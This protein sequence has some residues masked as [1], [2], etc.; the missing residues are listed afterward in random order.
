M[1]KI[2]FV[3]LVIQ[4]IANAQSYI[5]S[6]YQFG[7]LNS[8]INAQNILDGQGYLNENFKT[9]FIN[10]LDSENQIFLES[11]Y[12]L[13]YDHKKKWGLGYNNKSF[14]YVNFSDDLVRLALFGNGAFLGEKLN[15]SPLNILLNNYS[16]FYY[17]LHINSKINS[18]LSFV[19]GHQ[20]AEINVNKADF[21][22]ENLGTSIEYSLAL[23]AHFSDT[24]LLL[25]PLSVN[26]FGI[27]LSVNYTDTIY[28]S[29]INVELSDFG[30]IKW[31][32]QTLNINT[33]NNY[34]FEGIE[35]NSFSDINE[36]IISD[37]LEKIEQDLDNQ[38]SSYY[39]YRLPYRFHMVIN[40]PL[41]SIVVNQF[42]LAFDYINTLYP[43]PRWLFQVH[44]KIKKS[45]FSLGYHYGGL[46]YP[47]L[48]FGYTFTG[49]KNTFMLYTKQANYFALENI[50]GAQIGLSYKRILNSN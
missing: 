6:E 7:L 29:I 2:I 11:D 48:E 24:S 10:Q 14:L 49:K 18:S 46:E 8:S 35:I 22:T 50:Y 15:L 36:N 16:Q 44:K 39:H 25:N 28:N 20:L 40:Q 31:N 12:L 38:T 23:E 47:G 33:E 1:R 37:E 30:L 19:L 42:T 3:L 9:N 13:E 45:K 34:S 4:H 43:N 26:G 21:T 32:N 17:K 41:K 27:A 5:K